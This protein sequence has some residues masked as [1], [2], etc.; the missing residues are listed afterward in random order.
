MSKKTE[1]RTSK[2]AQIL[3]RIGCV[4]IF[5]AALCFCVCVLLTLYLKYIPDAI[6]A[7]EEKGKMDNTIWLVKYGSL[8]PSGIILVSVLTGLFKL[9]EYKPISTQQDKAII[10]FLTAVFT[11]FVLFARV[12]AESQG[13][14]LPPLEGEEDVKSLLELSIGWFAAQILPFLIAF[15][16]HIT[17]AINEKKELAEADEA[18][19]NEEIE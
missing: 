15:F 12:R 14:Q 17:R 3:K 2:S 8:L 1:K 7:L 6:S 18:E 5:T 9:T 11:Y 13:W 19:K 16:Y 4:A 10:I